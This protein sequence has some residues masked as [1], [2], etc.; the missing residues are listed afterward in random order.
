MD[1][2][3]FQYGGINHV[4]LVCRDMKVTVDFYENV[5]DMPL[6]KTV[7]LGGGHGQHFFFDCGN[8][9][10]IAYFWYPDAPEAAPGIASQHLDLLKDEATTAVASM[11]HLAINVPLEKIDEYAKR[12]KARG[13]KCHIINHA[14]NE[15]GFHKDKD[16]EKV[17]IRSIYFRDPDGLALEF[18]AY[19]REFTADDIVHKPAT[20]EDSPK[21]MEMK[22]RSKQMFEAFL[23]ARAKK[24]AQ[25][26]AKENAN[27]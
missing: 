13:V 3:K 27:A 15:M 6:I 5:L 22:K 11:N 10:T 16:N 1:S 18:A 8:G 2:E 4:A 17:W 20:Y 25:E 19:T 21:W 9:A 23:A 26:K 7:E 24:K 14:D 12:L